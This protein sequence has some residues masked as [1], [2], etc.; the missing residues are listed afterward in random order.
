MPIVCCNG[1]GRD[2]TVRN[3]R[4]PGK[5]V[6]CNRCIGRRGTHVS[7]RRGRKSLPVATGEINE[8]DYSDSSAP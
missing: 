6:F 1:C 4:D 3:D 8:D 2:V 7:E 5:E